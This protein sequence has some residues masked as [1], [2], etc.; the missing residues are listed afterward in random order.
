MFRSLI[1]I[2]LIALGLTG[3]GTTRLVDSDV[4]SYATP[5]SVPVGAHYRFER[6]PSQQANA[7]QQARLEA[8][9]QQALAKV[10]LQRDDASASYSVQVSVGVK[11]DPYSPGDGPYGGWWPGWNFGFGLHSGHTMIGGSR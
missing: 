1:A 5:P 2:F 7:A 8:M 6:L 10:G 3:C 9:A 11:V 4:R